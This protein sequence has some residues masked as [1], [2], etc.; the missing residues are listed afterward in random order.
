MYTKY[1]SRPAVF[2]TRPKTESTNRSRSTDAQATTYGPLTLD[3]PAT[4]QVLF[5]LMGTC[6]RVVVRLTRSGPREVSGSC[7]PR[8]RSSP[9]PP[10]T[11]HTRHAQGT[12]R[13][14]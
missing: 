8:S 10:H 5:D 11:T 1:P 9:S 3:L 13:T 14:P 6:V 4:D 7:R 2:F 12:P